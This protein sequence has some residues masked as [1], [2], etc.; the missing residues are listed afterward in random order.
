MSRRLASRCSE[1]LGFGFEFGSHTLPSLLSLMLVPLAPPTPIA[2]ISNTNSSHAFVGSLA[3]EIV[4]AVQ[5]ALLPDLATCG[6]GVW[7]AAKVLSRGGEPPSI[8]L[9]VSPA[10]LPMGRGKK[11]S[12]S[13]ANTLRVQIADALRS[14]FENAGIGV[15]VVEGGDLDLMEVSAAI[16]VSIAKAT[17]AVDW[18]KLFLSLLGTRQPQQQ[19]SRGNQ[20]GADKSGVPIFVIALPTESGAAIEALDGAVFFSHDRPGAV[21]MTLGDRSTCALTRSLLGHLLASDL[22]AAAG[23]GAMHDPSVRFLPNVE[24]RQ[25]RIIQDMSWAS[26][27]HIYDQLDE[28]RG[29]GGQSQSSPGAAGTGGATPGGDQRRDLRCCAYRTVLR[30]R[31]GWFHNTLVRNSLLAKL[32]AALLAARRATKRA[33]S[34]ASAHA[35][36]AAALSEDILLLTRHDDGERGNSD[37]T[38]PH[39]KYN[40]ATRFARLVAIM[41]TGYASLPDSSALDLERESSGEQVPRPFA[42]I[43]DAMLRLHGRLEVLGA[44][45][46]RL[47]KRLGDENE[48]FGSPVLEEAGQV[49]HSALSLEEDI[50]ATVAQAEATL[51]PASLGGH[52]CEVK[53][54]RLDSHR[55]SAAWRY[56]SFAVGMMVLSGGLASCF[57]MIQ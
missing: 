51:G 37:T 18:P 29:D 11:A 43:G 33:A 38:L 32:D 23:F 9:F 22:A 25:G 21:A 27:W 6:E 7:N 41:T 54:R 14:D 47:A 34:F 28:C 30:R 45:F 4:S 40:G 19:H 56:A 3:A 5:F 31:S 36:D 39:E 12:T 10:I 1:L 52:G 15:D 8:S 48:E 44:K 57:S 2:S 53:W 50:E 24:R 17:A 16:R 49:L 42:G 35:F 20:K 26:G 13:Q 46:Y 55:G